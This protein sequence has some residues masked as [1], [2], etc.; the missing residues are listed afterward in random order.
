MATCRVTWAGRVQSRR[1]WQSHPSL[2]PGMLRYAWWYGVR[3]GVRS[4]VRKRGEEGR[5]QEG[6]ERRCRCAKGIIEPQNTFAGLTSL[7]SQPCKCIA[8]KPLESPATHCQ[9]TCGG[10]HIELAA[11]DISW[12]SMACKVGAVHSSIC[13][14]RVV[15]ARLALPPPRAPELWSERLGRDAL[16]SRLSASSEAGAPSELPAHSAR[17]LCMPPSARLAASISSRSLAAASSSVHEP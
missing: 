4:G 12:R 16:V 6:R 8:D 5:V 11:G 1:A 10:T 14:H 2:P 3:I 9:R 7:W 13:R 15:E 17:S